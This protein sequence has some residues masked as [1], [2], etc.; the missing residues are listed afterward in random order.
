MNL[1]LVNI[2][3]TSFHIKTL[4][5]T[6][7]IYHQHYYLLYYKKSRKDNVFERISPLLFWS[8]NI[9]VYYNILFE[10]NN[11]ISS[12]SEKTIF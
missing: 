6:Y 7:H 2:Q 12:R 1:R 5:R 8:H 10:S 3:T 11:S 9:V 4:T